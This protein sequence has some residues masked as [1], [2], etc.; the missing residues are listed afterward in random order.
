MDFEVALKIINAKVL[1]QLERN[2]S[3]L[4][5][6]VLRGSWSGKTYEQIAE[7][8]EYSFNY[9]MRDVGPKFWRLLS[10]V[11]SEN[12]HKNNIRTAIEKLDLDFTLLEDKKSEIAVKKGERNTKTSVTST[13]QDWENAPAKLGELWGYSSELSYLERSIVEEQTHLI[14]IWGLAG[15]GKTTLMKELAERLQDNFTIVCWRSLNHAPPFTDFVTSLTEILDL[16]L[17]PETKNLVPQLLARLR[18][19][20]CLLLLD[21]VEGILQPGQQAGS[22]LPGYEDYDKFFQL[23]GESYHQSCVITNSSEKMGGIFQYAGENSLIKSLKLSGLTFSAAKSILNSKQLTQ[24][25]SQQFWQFYQGNPAMLYIAS[26]IVSE[27][28]NDNLEEFLDRSSLVFGDIDRLLNRT[29]SRLSTLETEILYW[30]ATEESAVSLSEI[31]AKIPLSIYRVELLEAIESLNQRCFIE[32][33]ESSS[34]SAF[35]LWPIVGEFAINKFITDIGGD[36]CLQER[37]QVRVDTFYQNI[38]TSSALEHNTQLSNWLKPKFE[39]QGSLR[40]KG[41]ETQHRRKAQTSSINAWED[42]WQHEP[43]KGRQDTKKPSYE[44]GSTEET[45][46]TQL[47][48]ALTVAQWQPIDTLL[49]KSNKSSLRMRSAFHLR[50]RAAIARFKTINLANGKTV[51]L[52]VAI[53]PENLEGQPGQVYKI[54]VQLQP[55][56]NQQTLPE[57]LRISLLDE[58]NNVI[59]DSMTDKQKNFI[60]LPYFYGE[61]KEKFTIKLNLQSASHLEKF[62]I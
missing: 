3:P 19:R 31:Q 24:S 40:R 14:N 1:K 51:L 39:S 54:C 45:S 42:P 8:S 26:R 30:L 61:V 47:R 38:N 27:L 33:L 49:T 41:G 13:I 23:V 59:L 11:F 35:T 37:H 6:T 2:L 46:A 9:L 12:I 4:E 60:Q 50:G 18:S 56:I 62:E 25:S 32:S 58:S 5:I 53:A 20:S 44:V 10:K 17:K 48:T 29:F 43:Q 55:E 16:D 21:S 7:S 22:Y 28:F 57:N 36:F 52:L 15:I 34:G